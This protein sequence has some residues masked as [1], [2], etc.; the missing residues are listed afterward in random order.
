MGIMGEL[1]ENVRNTLGV[2]L[3]WRIREIHVD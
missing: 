1:Q 2:K 3:P